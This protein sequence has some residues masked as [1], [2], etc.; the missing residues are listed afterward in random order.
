MPNKFSL[1]L[2]FGISACVAF[3]PKGNPE[4]EALLKEIITTTQENHLQVRSFDD[5][6][7]EEMYALYLAEIDPAKLWLTQEDLKQLVSF[8]K[9]IAK[10]LAAGQYDFFAA[11]QQRLLAAQT[12]VKNI[13][14]KLFQ[15]GFDFTIEENFTTNPSQR[16]WSENEVALTER[17]RKK[18]KYDLLQLL[19]TG[20]QTGDFK[21]RE[22]LAIEKL[23]V[24]YQQDFK[25][26]GAIS[27]EVRRNQYLNTYLKLQDAQT[28]YLSLEKKAAWDA[29]YTR[30]LVGIGI[31]LKLK[32]AYP[33]I[34]KLMIGSPA[35]KTKQVEVGDLLLGIG[36]LGATN[37]PTFG[38]SM[39][40]IL[41]Q[42]R[43]TEGSQVQLKIQ[44]MDQ[45]IQLVTLS[46]AAMKFDLATSFL[47]ST[48]ADQRK[49]GYLRLPRFYTGEEGA[50]LHVRQA[51]EVL[52]KNKAT[53]LILDLRNNQG[54]SSRE[55]IDIISYFLDEGTVM[56]VAYRDGTQ[57]SYED[58]D[59]PAFYAGKLIV[60]VNTRSSSASE[61]CAGTLQDYQR[62]LI[63][64]SKAT[65]GKGTMQ[66]FYP[67]DLE[68][69]GRRIAA[70][71][72]KMTIGRF[73]TGS[74][75]SPQR[76]GIL[77]DIVLPDDDT[78]VLTGERIYPYAVSNNTLPRTVCLQT[79]NQIKNIQQCKLRS[80]KRV[81]NN[82]R[83]Q[84][85]D[86]K[87]KA[88]KKKQ[89]TGKVSLSYAAYQA[90][91]KTEKAAIKQYE[92]IYKTLPDFKVDLC[93]ED[94]ILP[95]SSAQKQAK[96]PRLQQLKQDPYLYECYQ[97][98]QD[99]LG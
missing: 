32:D 91:L 24:K 86:Q 44:K 78:Y 31:N 76:T 4:A 10:E 12:K 25:R 56:Q 19:S 13:C 1:L 49:I 67:I 69:E 60:M 37:E 28:Q 93:A 59:G 77:A 87:A 43:G 3:L 53:G 41:A 34:T 30:T 66:R 15:E 54:G 83:F 5:Q 97:I 75:R 96:I 73:Y 88:I 89:E 98:M 81:Q 29:A 38:K 64:G 9:E 58:T 16:A 92:Q 27:P 46:R 99:L 55:A 7:S 26:K 45:S 65:Y 40:A 18:I 74:G 68:K 51:I 82:P 57:R 35:W 20:E 47:L 2:F 90:S 84:L 23:R 52:E 80:Q 42:L 11:T 36:E 8:E 48:E 63:V 21:K 79:V 61:L 85:A 50:A 17:W 62:A 71:E 39:E 70:G 72:I 95:D 6:L 94:L 14:Q 22:Q 33:E